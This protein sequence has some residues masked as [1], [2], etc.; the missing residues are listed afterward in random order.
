MTQRS[1]AQRIGYDA[2]RWISRMIGVTF[3]NLR[4]EGRDNYPDTGGGLVCSN[5]QSTLDPVLVGLTCRRRMNYLARQTLFK[6]RGFRHL[7]EFLDAIPIDR[8]GF[9]LAGI[10]ETLKRLRR[11]ELV[12]I[13]PEGTRTPDG[14][15]QPLKPGIISLARR[16]RVPLIPVGID[17]AYD[18]WPRDARFPWPARIRVVVGQP[19]STEQIEQ[20][21]DDR[22]LAE[23]HH[24]IQSCQQQAKQSRLS[25]YAA[26]R[27]R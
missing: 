4:C 2:L 6:Q 10:K 3:F 17:G 22:L 25:R 21:D 27:A 9:G 1:L 13:F 11:N 15:V 7:I 5:H 16:G 24:R 14:E 12:L 20:L 23:L 8:E 18:A 26:R 19:I